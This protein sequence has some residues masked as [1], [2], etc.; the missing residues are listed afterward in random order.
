ML[1]LELAGGFQARL[2]GEAVNLGNQK[3]CALLAYLALSDSG[4]ETREVLA[5]LL[6]SES[7][8]D[9]ARASLRQC[10][11]QIRRAFDLAN[12]GGFEAD[13]RHIGVDRSFIRV[14]L[15][16]LIE[17]L[18]A[19]QVAADSDLP[20]NI[21]D[22]MLYGFEDLD[23]AF[24]SWLHVKRQKYREILVELLE[25]NLS[26][27][28][29]DAAVRRQSARYLIEIDPTH[30]PAHQCLMTEAAS[31]GNTSA[32]LRIYERLW[33]L[34][35][36]EYDM[37]P[38]EETQRLVT[39]IKLGEV[40]PA[41]EPEPTQAVRLHAPVIGVASFEPMGPDASPQH[42]IAGFR[43]DLIASLVR[44]RDWVV[45]ET[46]R[47]AALSHL[48]ASGAA[49]GIEYLL[50]GA[51]SPNG[52]AIHVTTTLRE[53]ATGLFVWSESFELDMQSWFA[54]QQEIV[55][56]M[57]I[58]LNIYLSANRVASIV[59]EPV[60]ALSTYDTW[61]RARALI[62][63]W[64]PDEWDEAERMFRSIIAAEPQFAP[65][66][67]GIADI[68]NTR[69][70]VEPGRQRSVEAEQE[71]VACALQAVELDPLDTRAQ[72][73]L[74]WSF[75]MAGRFD[76][77]ELHF[78]MSHDLNVNNPHGII[79]SAHGLAFCGRYNAALRMTE[80]AQDL[81]PEMDPFQ[82]GYSAAIRFLAFDLE[83]CV[84]HAT[85]AGEAIPTL[86]GFMAAAQAHLGDLDGAAATARQ[87][88]KGVR[89]RW[90]GGSPATDKAIVDW[91]LHCFPIKDPDARDRLRDGLTMAGMPAA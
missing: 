16:D 87:F 52:D 56:R 71:A 43:R 23:P 34:L 11:R 47:D 89:K 62:P 31:T 61:L 88:A 73:A 24:R 77:A 70:I 44:F 76:Q 35:G 3:A 38:S 65:A 6:W 83:G 8:D 86:P 17:E 82:R 25:S 2:V 20:K 12:I 64:A 91:Y 79:S 7:S 29:S 22:R 55:R 84:E 13:W 36:E 51:Y 81:N 72:L 80:Q 15:L 5:G 66:Y 9:R 68:I 10:I 78:R 69:H 74:G 14:D 67:C 58:A 63:L 50:D 32:A 18:R 39:K 54:A 48:T 21:V 75:A 42:I 26:A 33:D 28:Q 60:A 85:A 40:K 19:G 57:A 49:N 45:L 4:R 27:P 53:T 1:R 30:E 46:T 90:R 59:A 41:P 37:E